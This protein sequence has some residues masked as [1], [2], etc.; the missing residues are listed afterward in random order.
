MVSTVISQKVRSYKNGSILEFRDYMRSVYSYLFLGLLCMSLSIYVFTTNLMQS[1][2]FFFHYRLF[3]YLAPIVMIAFAGKVINDFSVLWATIYYFS[4]CFII[5]FSFAPFAIY[6]GDVMLPA[7]L[8]SSGMF[9]G[10]S[11]YGYFTNRDLTS[12]GSY[13]IFGS[14]GLFISLIAEWFFPWLNLVNNIIG[15]VL[16]LAFTAYDTHNIKRFY[17]YGGRDIEKCAI[18][19]ALMLFLD[20]YNLLVFLLRF[21]GGGKRRD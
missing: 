2:S 8:I 6:Y 16:F 11:I 5:G 21:L 4:L 18:F 19:G 20:F 7:L 15:I 10:M 17:Y 3:F 14:I 13:I 12:I 9:L 1:Y